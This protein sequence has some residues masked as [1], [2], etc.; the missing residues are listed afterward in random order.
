MLSVASAASAI[1]LGCGGGGDSGAEVAGTGASGSSGPSGR[2]SKAGATGSPEGGGNPQRKGKPSGKAGSDAGKSGSSSGAP[3]NEGNAP[4]KGGNAG[5]AGST[6]S[7]SGSESG[8]SISKAEF[9]KQANA[10]CTRRQAEAL[11]A[12]T[13][14]VQQNAGDGKSEAQLQAE[15]IDTQFL[16]PIQ[17]EIDEIKALGTPS[18]GSAKVEAF[19]ASFQRAVDVVKK[20]EYDP[21]DVARFGNEFRTAGKLAREYGLSACAFS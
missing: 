16:P 18:Q 1:A 13:T 17:V 9:V 4:R 7:S 12:V 8:G 3:G 6:N 19:I 10:I 2:S 11:K 21:A 14:Y 20:R 5:G 15:A